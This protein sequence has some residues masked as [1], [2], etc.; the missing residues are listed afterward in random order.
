[1]GLQ[2]L[3]SFFKDEEVAWVFKFIWPLY[4]L[5]YCCQASSKSFKVWTDNVFVAW[6]QVELKLVIYFLFLQ[7]LDIAI[8]LDLWIIHVADIFFIL[9]KICLLD[10]LLLYCIVN[11][12]CVKASYYLRPLKVLLHG[13][14]KMPHLWFVVIIKSVTKELLSSFLCRYSCLSFD[15]S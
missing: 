4:N 12:I 14:L 7:T 15:N 9:C 8:K 6:N 10:I 11:D 2:L 3:T 1:M 13:S 5:L